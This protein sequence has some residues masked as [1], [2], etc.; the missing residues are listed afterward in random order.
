VARSLGF[1]LEKIAV[2]L[3]RSS[4]APDLNGQPPPILTARFKGVAPMNKGIR[5]STTVK[6]MILDFIIFIFNLV[7]SLLFSKATF[8]P[9][10]HSFKK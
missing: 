2:G 1:A 5:K 3:H 10:Y 6:M 8:M 4:V 9:S 7:S